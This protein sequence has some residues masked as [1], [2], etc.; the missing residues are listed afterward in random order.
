MGNP[1]WGKGGGA[2]GGG[3]LGLIFSGYVP[4]ASQSPYTLIS[5][6]HVATL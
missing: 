5:L 2:M 6:L 4:L 3:L 1:E